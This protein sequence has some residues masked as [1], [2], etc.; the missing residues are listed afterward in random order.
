MYWYMIKSDK[1]IK[2]FRL[3]LLKLLGVTIYGDF[4]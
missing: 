2:R 3:F 1:E 4:N